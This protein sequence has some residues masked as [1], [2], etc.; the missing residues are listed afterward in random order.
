[1]AIMIFRYRK[2]SALPVKMTKI[3]KF[4]HLFHYLQRILCN[5]TAKLSLMSDHK[6]LLFVY[7]FVCFISVYYYNGVIVFYFPFLL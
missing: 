6:G 5:F 4:K 3:L 2:L 1:M 7:L